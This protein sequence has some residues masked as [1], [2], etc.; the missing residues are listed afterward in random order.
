MSFTQYYFIQDELLTK[1]EL[2]VIQLLMK[3]FLNKEIAHSLQ[4]S[5]SA[6]KKH[7]R[8]IY[9]KLGITNRIAAVNLYTK[10]MRA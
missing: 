7:N 5:L 10:K 1:R 9:R 8:N 6:V 3:G 4:V 2:D